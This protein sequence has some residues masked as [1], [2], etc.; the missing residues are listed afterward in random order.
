M[1]KRVC[2]ALLVLLCGC[3]CGGGCKNTGCKAEKG[4]QCQGSEKK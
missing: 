1:K 4:E 2:L 3:S